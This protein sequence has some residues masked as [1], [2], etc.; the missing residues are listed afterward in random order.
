MQGI[1]LCGGLATRLGDITSTTPKCMLMF[2]GKPFLYYQLMWLKKYYITDII[3]CVGHLSDSIKNY[4]GNGKQLGI[5]IRY[6][7]EKELLGTAGA[8]KNAE[9][10]ITD[11]RLIVLN[12]DVYCQFDIFKLVYHFARQRANYMIVGKR[13]IECKDMGV[14]DFNYKHEIKAFREKPTEDNIKKYINAGIYMFKTD[15]ILSQIPSE[16][17]VSI[18]RETFPSLVGNGLFIY[19]PEFKF[20]IWTDIGVPERIQIFS[21]QIKRLIK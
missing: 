4:F 16:Q 17:K 10:L 13:M 1:I 3:L 20:N 12:G 14:I 18:E 21:K 19:K 6:S 7:Y 5:K 2:E 8:I 15:K 11:K 9:T